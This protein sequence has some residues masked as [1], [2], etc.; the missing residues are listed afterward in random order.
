M[1]QQAALL[2]RQ[3][4]VEAISTGRSL[5]ETMAG[6]ARFEI[7][8]IGVPIFFGAASCLVDA[9]QALKEANLTLEQASTRPSDFMGF[10]GSMMRVEMVNAFVKNEG[11]CLGEM[12]SKL[13]IVVASHRAKLNF[14]PQAI[15]GASL[16]QPKAPEPIDVR[17]VSMPG[18]VSQQ[19][20]TRDDDMEII[21]TTV[22][23]RDIPLEGLPTGAI[24]ENMSVQGL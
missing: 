15:V 4:M 9:Y 17:I 16:Q 22:I 3:V 2:G 7:S 6:L 14:A 23:E 24:D 20:V 12:L 8:S 1:E 21:G 13:C 10:G 19:T 11:Q 5:Y 18:R